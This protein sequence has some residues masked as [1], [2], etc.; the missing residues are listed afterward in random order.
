VE[1]GADVNLANDHGN[2]ALHYTVFWGYKDCTFYLLEAGATTDRENRYG[3]TA[4]SRASAELRAAIDDNNIDLDDSRNTGAAL[5]SSRG[6]T[7][8]KGRTLIEAQIE[9]KL[10]FL[11]KSIL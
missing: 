10:R 11:S 6:K 2:T 8:R 1:C 7:S 4:L 5:G 3:K 9:N